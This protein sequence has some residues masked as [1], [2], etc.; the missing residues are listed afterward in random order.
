MDVLCELIS[1][2]VAITQQIIN[3][4]FFPLSFLGI[5]PPSV[6]TAVGSALSCTF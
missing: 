4:A 2:F 1:P 5:N 6:V 3:I